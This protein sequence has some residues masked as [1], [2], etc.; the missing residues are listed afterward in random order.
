MES[1]EVSNG[2]V[3]KDNKILLI[4]RKYEPFIGKW[5]APGGYINKSINES[6][7]DCCV[8]EIKE[9]TGIDVEITKKIYILRWDNKIKGRKEEIHFFLC[10]PKS[11]DVIVDNEVSDAK[12]V[13][14]VELNNLE[15]IPGLIDIINIACKNN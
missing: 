15:L 4:K 11:E 6:V 7:E 14:L 5:A 3:I 1:R 13:D 8:R 2:I 12:W 10:K 9:E